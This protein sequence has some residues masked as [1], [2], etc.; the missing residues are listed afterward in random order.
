MISPDARAPRQRNGRL[1]TGAFQALRRAH[2]DR[3]I[4][5]LDAGV[6]HPF[7]PS[8][9]YDLLYQG[10]RYPPKAVFGLGPVFLLGVP[11][12]PKDFRAGEG[13]VCFNLL[14]AHA[15]E[16]APLPPRT[17]RLPETRK[18]SASAPSR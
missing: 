14:R 9:D 15:Y 4:E 6:Q 11:L 18:N 17:L 7:G 2:L 8:A 12:G 13:T 16:L 10:H 5:A 3:A 1:Q